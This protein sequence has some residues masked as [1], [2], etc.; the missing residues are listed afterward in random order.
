M[1][2]KRKKLQ[3]I[4]FK[5]WKYSEGW[6]EKNN[7]NKKRWGGLKALAW[8]YFSTCFSLA[9]SERSLVHNQTFQSPLAPPDKKILDFFEFLVKK[10][11]TV[12]RHR[13]IL[14]FC[15]RYRLRKNIHRHSH[16]RTKKYSPS[17][18]PPVDIFFTVTVKYIFYHHD[19]TETYF[20]EFTNLNTY[21]ESTVPI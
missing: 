3:D 5:F 14:I 15:H 6:R 20:I 4:F 11:M 19:Y 8:K 7:N 9:L 10:N 17:P 12:T 16:R 21:F 18:S 2:V 1:T 13:E